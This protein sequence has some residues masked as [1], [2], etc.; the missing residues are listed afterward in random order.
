MIRE[1]CPTLIGK[2][3]TSFVSLIFLVILS[4]VSLLKLSYPVVTKYDV[5]FSFD[6]VQTVQRVVKRIE[7]VGFGEAGIRN[8]FNAP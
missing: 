5:F 6:P 4:S 3:V 1:I 8:W 7:Q 2:M